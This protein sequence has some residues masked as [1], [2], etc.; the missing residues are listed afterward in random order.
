MARDLALLPTDKGY[1]LDLDKLFV[2]GS[3]EIRQRLFL[4]LK[5]LQYDDYFRRY[6]SSDNGIPWLYLLG[7]GVSPQEIKSWFYRTA[8]GTDG[9]TYVSNVTLSQEGHVLTISFSYSDV[10]QSGQSFTFEV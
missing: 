4:R 10:Y 9:V 8:M 7:T 1:I 6:K 2:D 3:E 5:E